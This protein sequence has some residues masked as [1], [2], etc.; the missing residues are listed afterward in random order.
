[1]LY[2]NRDLFAEVG[3]T[4][5]ATDWRFD[6][7]LDT[8]A[9]LSSGDRYGFTTR[10]GAYGDLIFV[11]ERLGARLLGDS[12]QDQPPAPT[13]DDPTVV[14]ALRQYAN[15]SRHRLLSPATPS[16]QSGW[17]DTMLFGNHPAGVESGQVA[18][19]IDYV[20]N[21]T[22]APPLSF[23]TGVLPLPVGAQASTEFAVRTFYVSR[24]AAAPQVCWEWLAFLSSQP[25]VVQLLP[26]RRSVATSPRWQGQTDETHLAAYQATL[27]YDDASIL[28]IGRENSWLAY[29]YPWL[30]EAFQAAV[31]GDD[32]GR[33]L[34]EAQRKA[35]AY[36]LCLERG[37]GLA[38]AG[39]LRTCAREVDPDYP[40]FGE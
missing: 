23:E 25:E 4:P 6:D 22:F 27:E 35:E 40:S 2:Y 29:A 12:D 30:D 32:A 33:A 1:M 21:Q 31:A 20:S 11:L 24:H 17:P 5:P 13:F 9:F 16:T 39:V 7:F 15:L 8:A 34:A 18:M 19:W 3:A 14:S 26:V 37:D 28:R 10:D 36:V 38:N